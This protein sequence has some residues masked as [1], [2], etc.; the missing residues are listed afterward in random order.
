MLGTTSQ[1]GARLR[2][3]AIKPTLAL[4]EID[5]H[6]EEIRCSDNEIELRFANVKTFQLAYKELDSIEQFLLITSHEGCNH[7]GERVAYL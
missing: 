2:M 3:A 5:D 1:F 7:D 6:L 4:E